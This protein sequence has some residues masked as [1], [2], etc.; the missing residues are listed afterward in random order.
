MISHIS[1]RP[2]KKKRVVC[3]VGQPS[4]FLAAYLSSHTGKKNVPMS[5]LCPVIPVFNSK[6]SLF[7]VCHREYVSGQHG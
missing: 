6:I 1:I 3:T 7:S 5:G 2:K 4:L